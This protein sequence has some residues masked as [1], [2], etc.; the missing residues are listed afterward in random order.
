MAGTLWA[1]LTWSRALFGMFVVS[2]FWTA[3]LFL[4][5]L[6]IAPGSAVNL[7]GGANVVDNGPV[8]DGFWLYPRL[9]YYIGDAQCHQ[10][11]RRTLWINGNQ[12]P[13]DAR[14][15]SM[16]IFFNFGLLSAVLATPST[17]IG[18]TI[19]NGMPSR[20][21]RW[22]SRVGV[23]RFP[24]LLLALGL[25]PVAVDGFTQLLT[26]YEST[27]ATRILTGVPSG[28]VGGLLIGAMF[29][30]I[31]QFDVQYKAH[32]DDARMR[33]LPRDHRP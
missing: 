11:A 29:M 2:L 8:Y 27:N 15:T 7:D 5:P 20:V 28:W 3:S 24:I 30:S 14:M 10:I 9:I 26:A 1:R 4:A 25:L 23:E 12:M 16:Y 13:I 17:S 6:S 31:R 21:R 22:A 18:V 33:G 19:V 32:R